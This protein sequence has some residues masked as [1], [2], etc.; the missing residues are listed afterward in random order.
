MDFYF[1]FE[2]PGS[3]WQ[4]VLA[5]RS[6]V[7]PLLRSAIIPIAALI[8]WTGVACGRTETPGTVFAAASLASVLPRIAEAYARDPGSQP[9]RFSFAASSVLARQIQRGAPADI[10]ITAH[11]RWTEYLQERDRLR[12]TGRPLLGGR[13]ALITTDAPGSPAHTGTDFERLR[14]SFRAGTFGRG[15]WTVG[16][17]RHVPAG[18]YARAALQK[19]DWWSRI[20]ARLIPAA[21]ARAALR[22]V[23]RGECDYAIVYASDVHRPDPGVRRVALIPERLHPPIR[24][25]AA[26]TRVARPE[27]NAFFDFLFGARAAMIFQESGFTT[28]TAHDPAHVDAH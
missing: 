4:R 11:P 24:Y 18:I 19:L 15:R 26:R 2:A 20:E 1:P 27:A 10:Y 17:P 8:L 16:D 21:D 13:L 28:L 12:E 22:Y 14:R 25:M 7:S 23:S 3:H 9:L 6:L 5:F